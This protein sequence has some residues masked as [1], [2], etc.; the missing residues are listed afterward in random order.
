MIVIEGDEDILVSHLTSFR[1]ID[2][3]GETIETPFQYLEVVNVFT[4]HYMSKLPK[5][6]LSMTYLE[7]AKVI[8]EIGNA[9]GWGKLV[10]VHEKKDNF[11]LGYQ[12]SLDEANNQV[13]KGH[14]PLVEETFTSASHIFL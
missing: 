3:E 10:E 6:E 12:P 5:L 7:G 1:Y 4:V 9:Q 11:G 8:I 14:T 13:I 2:I